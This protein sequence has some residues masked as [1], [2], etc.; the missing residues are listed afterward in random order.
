[1]LN[2]ASPRITKRRCHARLA[3]GSDTHRLAGVSTSF[4]KERSYGMVAGR[5]TQPALAAFF[6]NHRSFDGP[7][8]SRVPSLRAVPAA[9]GFPC[10][11]R[12]RLALPLCCTQQHPESKR[13]RV[14]PATTAAQAASGRFPL[15][16]ALPELPSRGPCAPLP[17][18]NPT[19]L[20]PFSFH[21][22]RAANVMPAGVSWLSCQSRAL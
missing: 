5:P 10:W 7:N 3:H 2:S 16:T 20:L 18:P 9:A 15:R 8:R 4:P 13:R 1:M 6:R 19:L 11:T 21:K 14:R 17:A 22:S 12:R